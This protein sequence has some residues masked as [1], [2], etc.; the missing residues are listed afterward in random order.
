MRAKKGGMGHLQHYQP[1]MGGF[2]GSPALPLPRPFCP[3][4]G[5]GSSCLAVTP[6]PALPPQAGGNGCVSRTQST[7]SLS[8]T[9]PGHR[10]SASA[11][12]S[13]LSWPPCTARRN[14]TSWGTT[15]RRWAREGAGGCGVGEGR[16]G[17]GES[18]PS[19][20]RWASPVLARSGAALVDRS[21]HV[22]E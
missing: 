4:G 17:A 5:A 22:T 12:G 20:A 6:T 7:S 3:P 19:P 1:R 14:W 15:C 18:Q 9:P 21:A 11:C 13:R 2:A 8:P 10:H 16:P